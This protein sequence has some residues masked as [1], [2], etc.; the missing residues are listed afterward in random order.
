MPISS[1]A[2]GS[3][4]NL[5]EIL[6]SLHEYLQNTYAETLAQVIL[7]GSQARNEADTDSDIDILIVLKTNFDNYQ[8]S[9]RISLFISDLCLEYD[10]VVTCFFATLKQWQ[11]RNSALFRNIRSEGITL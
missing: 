2:T 5:T 10:V 9:K 3:Y 8:E 6:E 4:K 1:P 7:F 11:T